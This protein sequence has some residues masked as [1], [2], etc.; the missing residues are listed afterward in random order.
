M[1]ARNP[2]DSLTP[3]L[4]LLSRLQ[5]CESAAEEM[6][7]VAGLV[8]KFSASI[9]SM[10]DSYQLGDRMVGTPGAVVIH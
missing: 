5:Q 2:V 4:R 6:V 8:G 7:A 9:N 3:F 1:L 10:L